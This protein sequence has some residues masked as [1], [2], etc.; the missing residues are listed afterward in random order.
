MRD[1]YEYADQT[2]ETYKLCLIAKN[3]KLFTQI[4]QQIF[5][6]LQVKQVKKMTAGD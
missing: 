4:V 3:S 6:C 1:Q 2:K 5:A